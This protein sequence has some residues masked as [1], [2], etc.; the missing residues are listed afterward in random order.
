M[1]LVYTDKAIESLQEVLEFLSPKVNLE[2]LTQIRDEI[3]DKA[4]TL[5]KHPYLGQEEEYLEH[6][7]MGHRRL[8]QS[9]YKIIYRIEG[10]TIYITDIFDSRQDPAKMKG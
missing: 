5:M 6:L 3:L 9:R 7:Q 10:N 4:D 1:K 8:V 2:K